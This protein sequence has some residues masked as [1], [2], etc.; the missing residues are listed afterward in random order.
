MLPN[1]PKWVFWFLRKTCAPNFLDEL[2]GDLL[3]LFYRELEESGF[4]RARR[5]FILRALLSPRWYR[6]PHF[7]QFT[8]TVMYKTHF[9]VAMRHARRHRSGLDG[10]RTKWRHRYGGICGQRQSAS[11]HHPAIAPLPPLRICGLRR[12]SGRPTRDVAARQQCLG[13]AFAVAANPS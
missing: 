3:E 4:G 11:G 9:K 12:S 13:A 5:Q 1:P 8:R 10:A 6:L 7:S 2:Q